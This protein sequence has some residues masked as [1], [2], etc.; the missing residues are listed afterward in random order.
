MNIEKDSIIEI[1][2]NCLRK[3]NSFVLELG[4]SSFQENLFNIFICSKKGQK[5]KLLVN[6]KFNNLCIY[7][8]SNYSVCY[9]EVF[10][11]YFS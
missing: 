8:L 9:F 7:Q 1:R 3:K 6:I 10:F 4:I 2:W 5:K 11:V